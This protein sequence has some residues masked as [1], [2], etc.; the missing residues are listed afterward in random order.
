MPAPGPGPCRQQEDVHRSPPRGRGSG[1]P[2][3]VPE[4]ETGGPGPRQAPSGA[5]GPPGVLL[6]GKTLRWGRAPGRGEAP[7]RGRAPGSGEDP[8][9]WGRCAPDRG[10]GPAPA[11]GRRRG[12][13][14]RRRHRQES[15]RGQGRR[16]VCRTPV[17]PAPARRGRRRV[18]RA[19]VQRGR[20]RRVRSRGG[21][22]GAPAS[23]ARPVPVGTVPPGPAAVA[24]R[25]Q[26]A[27]PREQVVS[28]QAAGPPGPAVREQ[29]EA[30][31]APA[32]QLALALR[33]RPYR[34]CR[35][36]TPVLRLAL[37]LHLA[38]AP[39][40]VPHPAPALRL[41][42]APRLALALHPVPARRMLLPQDGRAGLAESVRG[43]GVL[44]RA[45]RPGWGTAARQARAGRG[46]PRDPGATPRDPDGTAPPGPSW[47]SPSQ[48]PDPV[49]PDL[50][51]SGSPPD[52]ARSAQVLPARAPAPPDRLH[53]PGY[54]GPPS[55][56][57]PPGARGVK[58]PARPGRGRPGARERPGRWGY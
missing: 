9:G 42:P 8:A 26:A 39:R 41:V 54:Q 16:P 13:R 17:G 27:A 50:V 2:G 24:S 47:G 7:G 53:L 57:A 12:Q 20:P 31:P 40:P 36:R 34:G 11:R 38:P 45:A 51:L 28:P 37:V 43:A 55:C 5:P 23:A 6:R 10:V 19:L 48:A 49:P 58:A 32:P 33:R 15:A 1:P 4:L 46:A 35:G 3:W 22:A 29:R 44:A 21:A 52:L 18:C 14:E 56:Q 30:P 25:D